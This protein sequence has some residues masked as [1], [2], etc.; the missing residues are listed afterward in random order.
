[1]ARER[2]VIGLNGS[3]DAELLIRRAARILE[4]SDGGELV[5]VHVRTAED[6]PGESPQVLEAQRR[7]VVDL[8]GSYHTLSAPDPAAALLDYARKS[9]ATHIVVGQSRRGPVAG[10]LSGLLS[11]GHVETRVVRGAGDIDVQV[12]PRFGS[13]RAAPR[14]RPDLGRARVGTGFALAAALPALLQLLLAAFDHSVATAVLI[15]LA[16]AVA[17]ALVGGLWPAVVGALWSSVLVNYFSTPPLGDLAISDPQDLLSL[18]VFVGVSAAVAGVVDRSARRSKE[19]ARAQA[20]SATLADLALGA[21]RSEDTLEGILAEALDVFGATGAGVFSSREG[22]AEGAGPASGPAAGGPDADGRVWRMVAGAGDTAGWAPGVTGPAGSTAEAVDADTRLVLFGR[23]VP[24][25]ESRLLGA[26]AVHVKA[27]LE[28]RQLAVSRREVLRLAE[29]N[30]MRTAILR[31]VSHD[32]RTPLAGIKLAAGALLQRTVSYT[33]EE[34]RELL[35]TIDECTDRLD[36]LVG[37]LLDMSRIT[38][39]SVRPMLGPVRWSDVVAA[40]LRGLPDGT[41]RVDLP[42]NMPTV[43]A[44]PVLLERVIANIVENAVKYAP[45]SGITITGSSDGMGAATLDGYPSGELRIIDHGAGVPARKVLDMFRPF[46]RLHD[47]PQSTGVGLGLAVADGFVKAM[48]GTLTAQETAGGGLTM[49][50]TLAL[51]TGEPG[52]RHAAAQPRQEAI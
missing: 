23:A 38:A 44:D 48:G 39:D 6:A 3:D 21:S 32:L 13:Q 36:Q 50:V 40:A 30:T 43:E 26:F 35:E 9:G 25:A 33:P 34:V 19:A 14:R 15:Q 2:I 28:R 52:A 46:Q 37:N 31:A 16:G 29:G 27:Q 49:V 4:R 51:S 1:M 47:L 18:G 41:V 42:A 45:G 24:P 8:G 22:T 20:E 12:V 10:L 5:A 11:G 7:L 17:V